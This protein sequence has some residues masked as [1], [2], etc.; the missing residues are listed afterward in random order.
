MKIEIIIV[1][2]VIL[3]VHIATSY[4]NVEAV[5]STVTVG[6]TGADWDKILPQNITI[7]TG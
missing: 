4:N 6:G 2:K 3:L 5:S 1:A 7:N